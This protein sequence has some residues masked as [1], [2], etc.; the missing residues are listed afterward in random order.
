MKAKITVNLYYKSGLSFLKTRKKK[1]TTSRMSSR[2]LNGK[3]INNRIMIRDYSSAKCISFLGKKQV[4]TYTAPFLLFFCWGGREHLLL[5]RFNSQLCTR[6]V[7]LYGVRKTPVTKSRSAHP[8]YCNISPIL[9]LF[10]G[11]LYSIPTVKEN[12]FVLQPKFVK[13]IMQLLITKR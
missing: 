13:L 5:L 2:L 3:T 11:G 4:T 8:I 12:H 6:E 9:V 7:R 1:K 10:L